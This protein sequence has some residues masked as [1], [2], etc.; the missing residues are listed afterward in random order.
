MTLQRKG[1]KKTL[2]GEK[3]PSQQELVAGS[4]PALFMAATDTEADGADLPSEYWSSD[5]ME[6]DSMDSDGRQ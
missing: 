3:V 5:G 6:S 1:K 4:V 2:G